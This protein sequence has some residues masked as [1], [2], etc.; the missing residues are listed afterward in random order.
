MH[1]SLTNEQLDIWNPAVESQDAYN[2]TLISIFNVQSAH[3]YDANSTNQPLT[4]AFSKP[5]SYV[6]KC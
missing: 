2:C 4:M 3:H 1:V 6:I 5:A